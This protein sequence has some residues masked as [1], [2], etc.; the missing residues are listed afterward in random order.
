YGRTRRDAREIESRSNSF[1]G[2]V[3]SVPFE[4]VR[5]GAE[6]IL[7]EHDHSTAPEIVDRRLEGSGLGQCAGEHRPRFERIRRGANHQ[8][9]GGSRPAGPHG[10][11]RAVVARGADTLAAR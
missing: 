7:S 1:A 2:A 4:L 3:A 8:F 5:A 6:T 9:P 11:R 10:S